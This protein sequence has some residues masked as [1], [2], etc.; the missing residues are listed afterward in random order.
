MSPGLSYLLAGSKF[1]A[2]WLCSVGLPSLMPDQA[3]L[4]KIAWDVLSSTIQNGPDHACG[5]VAP[6]SET[7]D[8][9]C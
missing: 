8:P 3:Y 9:P 7:G 2:Q 1:C 4:S 6:V 5:T